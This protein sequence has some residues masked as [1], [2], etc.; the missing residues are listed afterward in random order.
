MQRRV[1][2]VL[3]DIRCEV[4]LARGIANG[5]DHLAVEVAHRVNPH[6]LVAGKLDAVDRPARV[7]GRVSFVG[8]HLIVDVGGGAAPL[9]HREDDISLE[10]LGTRRGFRHGARHDP[11]CPVR[12]HI[13][14]S[15]ST[16]AVECAVHP[17]AALA[18][19]DAVGPGV[20]RGIEGRGVENLPGELIAS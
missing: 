5:D 10:A 2:H 11:V 7:D 4:T 19:L 13:D 20:C 9:P 15:I 16:K 1:G 12:I 8:R 14:G 6:Q 17:G 3:R 18:G